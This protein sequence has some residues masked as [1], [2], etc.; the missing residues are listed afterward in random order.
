MGKFNKAVSVILMIFL[1]LITLTAAVN[2]YHGIFGATE[3]KI[4]NNITVETE[5][6]FN[7]TFDEYG[8]LNCEE[9]R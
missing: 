4:I 7:C 2:L 6:N 5:R 1:V 9:L 8:K 3:H